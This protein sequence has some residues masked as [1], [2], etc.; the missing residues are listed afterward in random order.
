MAKNLTQGFLTVRG[1]G[2]G[3]QTPKFKGIKENVDTI[4]ERG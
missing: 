4:S 3:V 1:V 2:L